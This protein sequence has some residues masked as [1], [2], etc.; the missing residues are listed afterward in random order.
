MKKTH[1]DSCR[2]VHEQAIL[3]AYFKGRFTLINVN[4]CVAEIGEQRISGFPSFI[5][6][7]LY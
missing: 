7:I 3:V 5:Y 6:F 1:S 4:Y 2:R